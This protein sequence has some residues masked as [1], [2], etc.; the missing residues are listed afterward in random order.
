M[1]SSVP[2]FQ[3]ASRCSFSSSPKFGFYATRCARLR[4][5][6][7]VRYVLACVACCM[8]LFMPGPSA[9]AETTELQAI[10]CSSSSLLPR[11]SVSCTVTLTSAAPTEGVVVDLTSNSGMV[12]VPVTVI[13]E[14]GE[15]TA[16]FT[17][18]SSEVAGVENATVTA[19]AGNVQR[20]VTLAQVSTDTPLE[21]VSKSSGKCLTEN[22]RGAGVDQTTCSGGLNQKWLFKVNSDGSYRLESPANSLYLEGLGVAGKPGEKVILWQPYSTNSQKWKL[23]PAG[24][25]YYSLMLESTSMCLGVASTANAAAAAQYTCSGASSEAWHVVGQQVGHR[26]SLAWRGS[27]SP[28]IS[29]YYVY[30]GTTATG[31]LTRLSGKLAE[32]N[33]VDANVQAGKTYYYATTAANSA[34]H[35]SG[36]SN[37]VK[38][39]IP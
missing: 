9:Q 38:A 6:G 14:S 10:E 17:A 31:Y 28:G 12:S 20:A 36:Y 4:A 11:D 21:L 30:R 2:S 26:V 13:V 25:G 15:S 8:M 35:E 18:N 1:R 37:K 34:N 39:T 3:L 24:S 32:T 5:F 33:Y 7:G 27:T 23:Q 16:S 29:G 19:A 22:G